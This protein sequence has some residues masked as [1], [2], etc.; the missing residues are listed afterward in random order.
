FWI[1]GSPRQLPMA[2]HEPFLGRRKG[3]RRRGAHFAQKVHPRRDIAVKRRKGTGRLNALESLLQPV[4]LGQRIARVQQCRQM[5][6]LARERLLATGKRIVEAA[7][8]QEQSATGDESLDVMRRDCD[9]MIE[10]G[11][12]LLP[13]SERPQ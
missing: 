4:E 6:G 7:M 9:R 8:R 10:V 5:V 13:T 11:Q 3:S 12:C 1:S 2:L